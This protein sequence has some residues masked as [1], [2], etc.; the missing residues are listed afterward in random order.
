[1]ERLFYLKASIQ[2]ITM[3]SL[4]FLQVIYHFLIASGSSNYKNLQLNISNNII[5]ILEKI[6]MSSFINYNKK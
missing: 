3:L 2:Y 5:D 1:M 4:G 6:D